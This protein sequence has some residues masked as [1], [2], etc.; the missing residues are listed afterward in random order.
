MW[1]SADCSLS[2]S[3]SSYYMRLGLVLSITMGFCCP[4]FN[5]KNKVENIYNVFTD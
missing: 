1:S 5:V 4:D 2:L 3:V